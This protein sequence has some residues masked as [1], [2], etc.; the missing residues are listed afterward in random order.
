MEIINNN[1]ILLN[2]EVSTEEK[3]LKIK[4]FNNFY[5]VLIFYYL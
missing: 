2:Q 5:S 3:S 4:F 1:N